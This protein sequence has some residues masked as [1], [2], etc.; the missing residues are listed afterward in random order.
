MIVQDAFVG[1]LL[2]AAV[3]DAIGLPYEGLSPERQRRL[4]PETD[5]YHLLFGR[6][7]ISDDTEHAAMTAQSLIVSGGDPERFVRELSRQ[8]KIWLLG[9]PAGIGFATL[10]SGLKLLGGCP[11]DRSGVFSAGNGPA[12]R[13]PIIGVAFG[14]DPRKLQALVRASTRLTHT[15]PKAEYGALAVALAAW[16]S[17]TGHS[18][19]P[20]SYYS[21]LIELIADLGEDAETLLDLV[22][23]AAEYVA[24][25]RSIGE[26]A[27]AIGCQH[28][29]SGYVYQTVPVALFAWF[30]HAYS[31]REGIMDVVRCGGDTD[32]TAAITGAII[33]AAVGKRGIPAKWLAGIWEAPR[34]AAWLEALASHLAATM[35]SGQLGVALPM[36]QIAILP[37]NLVFLAAVLAHG[38]RRALPPY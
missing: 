17:A 4:F 23:Q 15:D 9:A 26:F 35:D 5:R 16:M 20:M 19:D 7:M 1:C 11:P 27:K 28:G 13:S 25:G 38:F 18:G 12:M 33:G 31:Y 24:A 36:N 37:R 6:G 22:E 30:R 21:S 2:G 29:V 10:R 34:S 8:M 3:G 32:T 14:H